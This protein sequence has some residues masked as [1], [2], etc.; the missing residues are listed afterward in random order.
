ME[1]AFGGK[2]FGIFLYA[3]RVAYCEPLAG[4]SA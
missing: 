1:A 3:F 2:S 4:D